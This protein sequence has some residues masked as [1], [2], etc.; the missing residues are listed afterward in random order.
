MIDLG[1]LV[2]I[3]AYAGLGWWT[4]VIRRVIGFAAV[5]IGFLAGTNAGPTA[6]NVILQ[7]FPGWAVPDAI[8]AGFFLLVVIVV[9]VIEVMAGFYHRK[10]QLAAMVFDKPTGAIVGGATAVLSI[11]VALY[12]LLGGAQ[13]VQGS[14]DGNQIQTIDT[15]RKAALAPTL[16][17]TVGRPSVILF[18]PVIPGDPNSYF[19]GAGSRP[20]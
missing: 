2:L 16:L 7:A 3:V 20:Q 11:T 8:T 10:L 4:G 15:I 19:N 13:P 12:L 17:K 9:L 6:A 1:I 14:P 18:S 5:Y